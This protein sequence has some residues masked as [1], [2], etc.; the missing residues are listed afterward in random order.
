MQQLTLHLKKDISACLT[1]LDPRHFTE[2]EGF[3]N[4]CCIYFPS[5]DTKVSYQ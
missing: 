2:V 3:L 1:S 4:F 5:S